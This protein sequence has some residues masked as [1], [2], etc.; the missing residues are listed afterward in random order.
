[1]EKESLIN[2]LKERI[3]ENDF[4]AISRRSVETIIEPLLP[5]FADDEKVTDETY[6]LPVA[7]LKS[8]IGQS[9]HDI[10]D[11]VKAEKSRLETEKDNAVRD[12]VEA[13]RAEYEKD[14]DKDKEPDPDNGK[15]S[16]D[17]IDGLIAAKIKEA[18]TG[19][20]GKDG[21]LGKLTES[22]NTFID[23][24]NKEREAESAN[25][26]KKRLTE[27]LERLGADQPTVVELAIEKLDFKSGKDFDSLLGEAKSGYEGLYKRLYSNGPMPFAGDSGDSDASTGFKSYLKRKQ[28][29][30]DRQAKD[31]ESL[32]TKM[33]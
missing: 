17:D 29:E 16:Q 25:D 9:R 13:L 1:M 26:L 19:L 28:D 6:A 4:A 18:F 24:Y 3:G 33:M 10:A 5:M 11:A 14:K 22:F 30:A 15:E 8:F 21:A 7:L 2:S 23:A 12:A 20:T 31:A 32:R 27:A